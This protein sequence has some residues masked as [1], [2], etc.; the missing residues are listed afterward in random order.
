MGFSG[1]GDQYGQFNDSLFDGNLLIAITSSLETVMRVTKIV[2]SCLKL[3]F[4]LKPHF[5]ST[6]VEL[7]IDDLRRK[8]EDNRRLGIELGKFDEK[9][10]LYVFLATDLVNIQQPNFFIQNVN[11]QQ[12]E[13]LI[14]KGE[15]WLRSCKNLESLTI[16]RLAAIKTQKR[17]KFWKEDTT[18]KKR[19]NLFITAEESEAK[20]SQ[21]DDII[22][23][24]D[25][26]TSSNKGQF[27]DPV[28]YFYQT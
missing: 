11:V 2:E 5:T 18:H 1:G 28:S 16:A 15:S 12:T 6:K 14:L 10:L 27:Y 13:E 4:L 9:L 26:P 19:K 17:L 23:I 8:L 22:I 7:M 25:Q 24:D 20:Q 21:V 3:K